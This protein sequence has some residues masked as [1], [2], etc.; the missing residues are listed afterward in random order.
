MIQVKTGSQLGN[1]IMAAIGIDAK[2]ARKLSL[3]CEANQL[4]NIT[5]EFVHISDHGEIVEILKR[6][7]LT[8][9]A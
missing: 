5:I 8:E 7:T 2:G 3:V 4:A 6:Y 9:A 1:E